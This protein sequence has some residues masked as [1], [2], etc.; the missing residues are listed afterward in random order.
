MKF[1]VFHL[2]ST[3]QTTLFFLLVLLVQ[4]PRGLMLPHHP[5]VYLPTLDNPEWEAALLQLQALLGAPGGRA[6]GEFKPWALVEEPDSE[7]HLER[8]EAELGW[9][10]RST[11]K[12][13]KREELGRR[14][15]GTFPDNHIVAVPYPQGGEVEEEEGGEKRNEAL[16]SIAGG[17][18]AFNRQ[19][20]GF[21]FRFGRK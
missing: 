21:G 7:E 12:G 11:V 19:K 13:Q 20:G 9:G 15:V 3:L 18:Q 4:P 16:T 5:M 8:A 6:A 1:Q 10:Q 14:P 17:L 2:S